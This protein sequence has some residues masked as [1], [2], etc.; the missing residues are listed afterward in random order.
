M[1]NDSLSQS[2]ADV[3]AML[4][5]LRNHC[6]C[7]SSSNELMQDQ[8]DWLRKQPSETE[9]LREQLQKSQVEC[10]QLRKQLANK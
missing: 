10:Q 4:A 5:S 9:W 7:V 8:L 3:Q 2:F 1:N 6:E